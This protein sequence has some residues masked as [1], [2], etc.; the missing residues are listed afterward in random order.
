MGVVGKPPAGIRDDSVF[1]DAA[2][3]DTVLAPLFDGAKAHHVGDFRRINRAHCVML[4]ETGILTAAHAAAIAGA[5]SE[6]DAEDLAQVAYTGEVEDLFFHVETSLIRRLGADL[7][8][9]LHTGRSRNDMDHTI[10][11]LSLKRK[12]DALAADARALGDADQ[13]IQ[14]LVNLVRNAL[15]ATP[16]EPR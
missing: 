12:I 3:R 10:F 7:A 9:R 13:V 11:R 2:Y 5:L 1:P 8:G 14:V 16:A 4:A 6:A 15:Q